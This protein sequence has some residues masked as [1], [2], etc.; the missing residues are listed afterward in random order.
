MTISV[1]G[2]L[3]SAAAVVIE[4]RA[5]RPAEDPLGLVVVS[6][7]ELEDDRSPAPIAV[8]YGELVVSGS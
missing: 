6:V 2:G 4:R 1:E 3:A 5:E 8:A 7:G